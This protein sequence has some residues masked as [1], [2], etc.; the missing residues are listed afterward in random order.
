[1]IEF[2]NQLSE[3]LTQHWP[4]DDASLGRVDEG[5]ISATKA[6][7]FPQPKSIRVHQGKVLYFDSGVNPRGSYLRISQVWFTLA[8]NYRALGCMLTKRQRWICSCIW[9]GGGVGKI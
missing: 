4:V 8:M 5:D 1:M 6:R 3:L 2:R 7:D 9:E